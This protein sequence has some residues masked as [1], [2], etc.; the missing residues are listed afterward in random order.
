MQCVAR[1]PHWSTMRLR[2][3]DVVGRP[4]AWHKE[5][6]GGDSQPFTA[7]HGASDA[8]T[9]AP[10]SRASCTA[11]A[12]PAPKSTIGRGWTSVHCL[13]CIDRP[14]RHTATRSSVNNVRRM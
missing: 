8:M 5:T 2:W 1:C 11:S 4:E 3:Q 7:L 14:N 6:P 13:R 10:P 12:A 9:Y